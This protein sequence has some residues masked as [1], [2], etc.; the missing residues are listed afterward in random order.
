M[1]IVLAFALCDAK[2]WVRLIVECIPQRVEVSDTT[3]ITSLFDYE[4]ADKSVIYIFA[5]TISNV[6]RQRHIL[7]R[8]DK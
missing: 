3:V 1:Y 6:D 5:N 4:I 2:E 8:E 7:N